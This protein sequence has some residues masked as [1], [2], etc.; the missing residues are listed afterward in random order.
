[1]S[2]IFKDALI[3]GKCD[4]PYNKWPRVET[5]PLLD[6][7]LS[8]KVSEEALNGMDFYHSALIGITDYSK[9]STEK[10]KDMKAKKYEYKKIIFNDP[11]TIILWEDGTKTVVKC[12]ENDT[13]DPE[14]GIALCFMKKILGNKSGPLNK[15]LKYPNGKKDK[16]DKK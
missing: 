16:E 10:R 7:L 2:N 5:N 9:I 6:G 11:A 15:I 14:K 3:D 4:S 1:M 12:G 13:Y 8:K